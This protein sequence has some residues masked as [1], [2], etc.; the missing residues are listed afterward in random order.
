M[1]NL[2]QEDKTTYKGKDVSE[3]SRYLCQGLHY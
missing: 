2:Y 3:F 1:K